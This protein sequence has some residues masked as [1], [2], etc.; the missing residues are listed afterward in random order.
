MTADEINAAKQLYACTILPGTFDKRFVRD[1][2]S[3]SFEQ[4]PK[5]LSDKQ[6]EILFRLVYK[7]RKQI[8]HTYEM[9]KTNPFCQAAPKT[10]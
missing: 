5:P 3:R 10:A 4:E 7:Y 9:Y 1:M 8:P 2:W 6:H